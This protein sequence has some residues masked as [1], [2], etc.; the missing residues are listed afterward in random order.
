MI[1]K[2]IFFLLL[3]ISVGA[4]VNLPTFKMPFYPLIV[5]LLVA[6]IATAPKLKIG[7]KS[8]FLCT[9]MFIVFFILLILR[10][11]TLTTNENT[12]TILKI[13][14]VWIFG[15]FCSS[16]FKDKKDFYTQLISFFEK[17]LVFSLFTFVLSNVLSFLMFKIGGLSSI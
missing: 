1:K 13:F 10:K 6:G 7:A 16:R 4:I 2:I 8:T 3:F 17:I 15:I 14:I 9:L 5:L 12:E 11:E